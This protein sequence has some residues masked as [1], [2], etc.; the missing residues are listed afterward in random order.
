MVI[1]RT[2][3]GAKKASAQL[4]LPVFQRLLPLVPLFMLLFGIN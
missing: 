2:T 4:S 3:T 1:R